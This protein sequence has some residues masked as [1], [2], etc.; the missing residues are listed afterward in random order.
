LKTRWIFSGVAVLLNVISNGQEFSIRR[1]GL[2]D[3]LPQ[4]EIRTVFEDSRGALLELS[5][6]GKEPIALETGGTRSFLEDGDRLT[7]KF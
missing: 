2:S 1:F 5:W 6:G 7:L 4:S 3:G